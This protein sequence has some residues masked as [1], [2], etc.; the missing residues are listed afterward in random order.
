MAMND[1][2]TKRCTKCGVKYP[3]T[4]EYF[5][6]DNRK[7]KG[8]TSAC[9]KCCTEASKR[10]QKA[11]PERV[12]ASIKRWEENNPDK[13]RE[14]SKR[15]RE[16][17][18]EK[19]REAAKK[20]RLKDVDK[21]RAADKARYKKNKD[22]I[23]AATARWRNNNPERCRQ[24][25]REWHKNNPEKVRAK[26]Q[27]RDAKRRN[28]PA[29]FTPEDWRIALEYFN[30]CCAYC[31][32]PPSFFDRHLLLHQDHYT[33][34][35]KGGAYTAN[36]IVPACQSCNLSKNDKSPQEWLTYKF[37]ARKAKAVIQ[38]INAYFATTKS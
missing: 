23:L 12:K 2:T 13:V 34:L 30:G 21:A 18:R 38:R 15:W 14:K 19:S 31:N 3:A 27:R 4:T 17:N 32:N 1:S 6:I 35:N 33:P 16:N 11:H 10:S 29:T 25:Q 20:S 7:P 9:R 37:G 36:N 24:T 28:L 5:S 26:V 8:L 22:K